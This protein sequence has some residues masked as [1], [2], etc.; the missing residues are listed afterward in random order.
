M[1]TLPQGV[2]QS[3]KVEASKS[4]DLNKKTDPVVKSTSNAGKLNQTSEDDEQ[5]TSH[6]DSAEQDNKDEKYTTEQNYTDEYSSVQNKTGMNFN[7]PPEGI[8]NGVTPT[9]NTK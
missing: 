4:K 2:S 6:K 7:K 5:Y 3:P 9:G 8:N 1:A